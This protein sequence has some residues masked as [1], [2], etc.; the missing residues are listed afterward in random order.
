MGLGY[1]HPREG[2]NWL[3]NVQYTRSY[4]F[5]PV[6]ATGIFIHCA[7]FDEE[8]GVQLGAREQ[9]R[10]ELANNN[11]E[12]TALSHTSTEA[13][14]YITLHVCLLPSHQGTDSVEY[15]VPVRGVTSKELAANIAN[16]PL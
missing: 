6:V 10:T 2:Q 4:L 5:I 15:T 1:I 12:F 9:R 16:I 14:V 8:G 11:V 13:L 7:S 3:L